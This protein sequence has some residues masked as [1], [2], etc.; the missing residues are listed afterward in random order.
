MPLVSTFRDDDRVPILGD[1][2]GLLGARLGA[3]LG[4]I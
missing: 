4:V 1:T 2:E 3:R